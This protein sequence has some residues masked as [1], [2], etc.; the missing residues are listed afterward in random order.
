M[1]I[2]DLNMDAPA[3]ELFDQITIYI[4]KDAYRVSLLESSNKHPGDTEYNAK[5]RESLS[6]V[7]SYFGEDV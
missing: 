4:L 7:L 2:K 3:W 1:D 5:F 6:F